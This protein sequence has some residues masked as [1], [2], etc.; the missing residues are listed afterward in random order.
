VSFTEAQISIA[1]MVL[2]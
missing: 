2:L 1:S